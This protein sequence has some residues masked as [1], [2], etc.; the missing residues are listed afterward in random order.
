M[1]RLYI[2]V[3]KAIKQRRAIY[4]PDPY[5][6]TPFEYT[7]EEAI[8]FDDAM[9]LDRYDARQVASNRATPVNLCDRTLY[10]KQLPLRARSLIGRAE[11]IEEFKKKN[12]QLGLDLK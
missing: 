12:E 7:E 2:Y 5:V 9:I 10:A 11:W 1:I 3:R 6:N 8:A 4:I